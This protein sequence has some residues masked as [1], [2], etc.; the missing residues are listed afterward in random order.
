MNSI[1]TRFLF[2]FLLYSGT[3]FAQQGQWAPNFTL[4]DINGVEY[5]LYDYL[6]EG[7]TVIID[8]AATWC[9]PCWDEHQSH[10]LQDIYEQYGPNGT[11]EVMVFF[12]EADPDMGL[13]QLQGIEGPSQGDWIEGTPYP[14]IDAPDITMPNAYGVIAYPT[15]YVVCPDFRIMDNIWSNEWSYDYVINQIGNCDGLTPPSEDAILHQYPT[16]NIDCTEGQVTANIF[17]GGTIPLTFAQ[18]RGWNQGEEIFTHLWTGNLALGEGEEIDLGS[19]PLKE[20]VNDFSLELMLVDFD[21]TNNYTQVP[22]DKAPRAA[23]ELIIYLETDEDAVQ[24]S[25]RW[26]IEDENGNIVD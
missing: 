6:A 3:T 8:F 20:G 7:K 9:G 15:I 24:D 25:T 5:R 17:N 10:V 23:N 12:I 1:F 2:L 19:Y 4:T 14:I 22:W 16:Y 13:A 11:D 26:Y 18:I 21:Q